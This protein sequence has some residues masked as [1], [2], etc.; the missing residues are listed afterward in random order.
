MSG[1]PIS[2]N[3]SARS[4]FTSSISYSAA[5]SR[6]ECGSSTPAAG[7]AAT[8]STFCGRAT[9]S[10]ARTPTRRRSKAPAVLPRRSRRISRP[11]HFHVEPVEA[12]SFPDAFADVVLSSAVLHFAR[13][14]EQFAAMLR[15][16]WRVFEAGRSVLLPPGLFDRSGR[17]GPPRGW[18]PV[19]SSGRIRALPRGR[20][21]AD[22]AD[23][24]TRGP[25]ARPAEND[26]GSEPAIDDHVGPAQNRLPRRLTASLSDRPQHPVYRGCHR[27]PA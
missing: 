5:A 18:T 6:P 3:S 9:T 19:P 25:I 23:R 16:S 10:S 11:S 13:G 14:D 1:C 24:T 17:P 12:M 20:S 2:R 22:F 27:L 4:T 26:R 8:W 21:D 15:G 7:P